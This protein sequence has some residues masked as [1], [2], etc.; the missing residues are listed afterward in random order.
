MR[1]LRM[2][3]VRAVDRARELG[4][5]SIFDSLD[6][7]LGLAEPWV[8]RDVLRAHVLRDGDPAPG[9]KFV[10]AFVR[11]DGAAIEGSRWYLLPPGELG[12]DEVAHSSYWP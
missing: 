5:A 11:S 7:V 6:K 2:H 3:F 1:V 4:C 10:I 12:L 8:D 9:T